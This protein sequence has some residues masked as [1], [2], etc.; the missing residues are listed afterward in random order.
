MQN[1][2]KGLAISQVIPKKK[3]DEL[4]RKWQID[5]GVTKLTAKKFLEV[6]T[7][8]QIFEKK[9]LRD[10]S[11]SYAV[12][13]ST[14]DDALSKRPYGF[15]QDLCSLLTKE[16]VC[17]TKSRKDRQELRELIAVDSSV[18]H[19]HG[20]MA[21]RY[22]NTS[23]NG[24][25]AGIKFHASYNVNYQWIEDFRVT[26]ARKTDSTTARKFE[27]QEGKTYIFDRAYVDFS[28]WSKID[29][30]D[31]KFV[32]RMKHYGQRIKRIHECHVDPTMT[33]ILYEGRWNLPDTVCYRH[34]LKSKAVSYRHIVYR[35]PESKKTFDFVTSDFDSPAIEIANI[36]RKRW[37]VELLFRWLKGHLNIRRF[38]FKNKNAIK[39]QLAV[40]VLLQVRNRIAMIK[41]NFS[42]TNWDYLRW[43]R[44]ILDRT[45]YETL[46]QQRLNCCVDPLFLEVS[47]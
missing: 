21:S 14:L 15:F 47:I 17:I 26:G 44:N 19:V 13:K 7:L 37:A 42:G 9:T 16:L 25:R 23:I 24:T 36:Y 31:A 35:D 12:P 28:L 11:Y 20:S 29:K 33:G 39:I 3:F 18:C 43:Q 2:V 40:A 5:K 30:A 1:F 8:S 38:S 4:V 22:V 27:F 46:C 45:F 34:G 10:V 41:E 32:T 6:L